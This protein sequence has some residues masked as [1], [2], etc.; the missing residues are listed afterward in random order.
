MERRL[1]G[2]GKK[3]W[4]T[5]E[6]ELSQ[7]DHLKPEEY[8]RAMVAADIGSVSPSTPIGGRDARNWSADRG[9]VLPGVLAVLDQQAVGNNDAATITSIAGRPDSTGRRSA[10][11]RWLTRPDNQLVTRAMVNR[12]WQYHF[13]RG[14]VATA[15]DFG[16]QGERP[17]HPELLDWLARRFVETGWSLKAM[18]RLILLSNTYRQSSRGG[19]V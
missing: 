13:G 18:H 15:N 19:D 3:K 5:L 12:L 16:R 4:E 10:L 9:D 14:L 2:E 6:K 1:K 11:A 7:F 8:P 17:T